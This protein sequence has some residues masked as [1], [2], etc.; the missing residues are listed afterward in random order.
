MNE[1]ATKSVQHPSTVTVERDELTHL[2]EMLLVGLASFGELE[3][4]RSDPRTPESLR[5]I[6]PTGSCDTVSRFADALRV[7]HYLERQP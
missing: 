2:R 3:R 7:L 6:H 4:I 1:Q 5:V